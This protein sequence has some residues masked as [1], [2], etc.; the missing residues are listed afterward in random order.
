LILDGKMIEIITGDL[1][2]AT[3]QYIAHQCNCL[4]QNSAGTAKSIFDKFPYANTYANRT[5]PDKMG[6]IKILGN[7]Q[8]QRFVIN[9]FAQYYPGKSKFPKS[10]LD[11]TAV[12]LDCFYKCLLRVARL[13]DLESIAFPWRIGCNLGG[14]DW[15]AYLGTITNFAQYVEEKQGTRVV[16]YRREGDV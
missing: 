7:G 4:T 2:E 10:T 8:D 11:G 12:R 6:S 9:M 14:G 16:I 13:P 5:E 15:A 3:E 1:L